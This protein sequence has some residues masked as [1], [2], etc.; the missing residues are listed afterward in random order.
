MEL[1]AGDVFRLDSNSSLDFSSL[2]SGATIKANKTVQVQYIVGDQGSNYEIRGLSAFPRGLWD[3][4]Y[5]AP[6][7]SGNDAEGDVDIFL[8][9]PHDKDL[10]VS[11][12]IALRQR[13]IH[14]RC[15]V[16]GV[17]PGENRGIRAGGFVRCISR[18]TTFSGVYP[19]SDTSAHDTDSFGAGRTHDWGYSLV[20]AFLLEK[21]HFMGWSPGAYPVGASAGSDDPDHNS[22]SDSGVFIGQAQDNTPRIRG[23]RQR[24][25]PGPNARPW[26]A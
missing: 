21:E 23:F 20:P 7:D 1:Q 19:P 18:E 22:R 26:K 24:R 11:L 2:D 4:E 3:D 5:Y 10:T 12:R 14:H 6:V 15:Q 13:E 9:N 8:Y 17:V 25:H 16:V